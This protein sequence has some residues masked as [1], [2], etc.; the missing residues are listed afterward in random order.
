MANQLPEST[1][2]L[3]S[4]LLDELL[5]AAYP[6]RGISFFT[7][8]VK[9]N[10]YWYM[11]YVVGSSKRS[12]YLGPDSD[13]LRA[14]VEDAEAL[15]SRDEA[16]RSDR[17]RLVSM[18]RAGEATTL[19]AAHARVLEAMEQAGVFIVGGVVVGS[20]AYA[21]MANMLG[22]KWDESTMR[23][24][25]VDIAHDYQVHV[26]VPDVDV[27]L[28]EALE[29]A[30]KGF[31]PVPTLNKKHPSTSF[32]VRGTELSVS[33]LTPM[34]G[35][36]SGEPKR[37]SSLDAM[38][39]PLRFLDYILEDIQPA[40]IPVRAGVLINVP[41]PARFAL[42]KLVVSQRRPA[43]MQTKSKKDLAQAEQVL[44]VLLEERPGDIHF[45]ADAAHEMAPKFLMQLRR[46]LTHIDYEISSEVEQ[47][48]KSAAP[49]EE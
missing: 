48:L 19:P 9:G 1:Q 5:R 7:R 34:R 17:T 13:D 21:A 22:V 32:S 36:P 15:W 26:T 14:R 28:V 44:R 43:A 8:E 24:Q 29:Q 45:A 31:F 11:Q 46:G 18:L 33:L 30:D 23:T 6:K 3:Y 35:P 49:G 25:D 4:Q 41:S 27:D 39:K 10:E 42:H 12:F 47:I 16:S 38:A 2:V 37:I 20:H 40:A